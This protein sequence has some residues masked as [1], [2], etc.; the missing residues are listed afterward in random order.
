L[1]RVLIL[2]EPQLVCPVYSIEEKVILANESIV[3]RIQNSSG[4]LYRNP[5]LVAAARKGNTAIVDHLLRHGANID[6]EHPIHGPPVIAA[7]FVGHADLAIM[8]LSRG[9]D[10]SDAETWWNRCIAEKQSH[11]FAPPS[12]S[13]PPFLKMWQD[14]AKSL[15]YDSIS[16]LAE[17]Y[18]SDYLL[19]DSVVWQW[20]VPAALEAKALSGY[21][22]SDNEVVVVTKYSQSATSTNPWN[23]LLAMTTSEWLSDYAESI[24]RNF[25]TAFL[26]HIATQFHE[27]RPGGSSK[28]FFSPWF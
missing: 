13:M 6:L 24:D 25:V 26:K 12:Y 8:L 2:T 10:I 15:E 1:R 4:P 14:A 9:A 27:T 19:F 18:G 22:C 11:G 23:Y 21:L 3:L 28:C 5:L 20:E 7:A 16:D 17:T